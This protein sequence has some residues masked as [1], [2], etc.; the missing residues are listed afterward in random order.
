LWPLYKVVF[1]IVGNTYH[2]KNQ[3]KIHP[4]KAPKKKENT[5][6]TETHKVIKIINISENGV[7]APSFD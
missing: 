2:G 1:S 7:N 5:K 3:K 6:L 4:E